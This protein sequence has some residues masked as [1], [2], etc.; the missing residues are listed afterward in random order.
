MDCIKTGNLLKKLRTES[1][2][3]QKQ[4]AERISVSDKAVSKWERGLGCPDVSVLNGIAELFGVPTRILLDGEIT[5]NERNTGNMK[6]VKF[7]VCKDCG[8][9]FTASGKGEISCCGR[10]L[11][12]LEATVPDEGH[13]PTAEHTGDEVYITFP[14]EMS[15]GHYISFAAYAGCERVYLAKMYPEQDAAVRMPRIGGGGVLY[16]YCSEHGFM[17]IKL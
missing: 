7:Y 12:A 10:K 16:F 9:I 8:N 5:E 11:E 2:M 3:T 6:R 17:K 1:G 13:T 4:V 14:H 15:K